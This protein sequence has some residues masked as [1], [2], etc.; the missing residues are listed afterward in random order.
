M[1]IN[2]C[3]KKHLPKLSYIFHLGQK[4]RLVTPL[5]KIGYICVL[6]HTWSCLETSFVFESQAQHIIYWIYIRVPFEETLYISSSS[7]FQHVIL[8]EVAYRTRF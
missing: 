4:A 7:L 6:F 1:N 8:E 5:E 3:K 2:T